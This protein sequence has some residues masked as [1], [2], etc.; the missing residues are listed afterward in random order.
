M[1]NKYFSNTYYISGTLLSKGVRDVDQ[2]ETASFPNGVY[3]LIGKASISQIIKN[4]YIIKICD[5]VWRNWKVLQKNLRNNTWKLLE[6]IEDQR[7]GFGFGHQSEQP[8]RHLR[9]ENK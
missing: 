7:F 4:A 9:V 2:E 8:L 5:S 3:T 6:L 1:F